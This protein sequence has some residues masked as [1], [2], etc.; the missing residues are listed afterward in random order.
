MSIIV[1]LGICVDIQRAFI[2]VLCQG[3]TGELRVE[4]GLGVEHLVGVAVV[5]LPE[6]NIAIEV[7]ILDV[8]A[9]VWNQNRTKDSSWWLCNGRHHVLTAAYELDLVV[10]ELPLL[11]GYIV[12]LPFLEND[13]VGGVW[14][15]VCGTL[16][17]GREWVVRQARYKA[18]R[19]K[20]SKAR[21]GRAPHRGTLTQTSIDTLVRARQLDLTLAAGGHSPVANDVPRS[22]RS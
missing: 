10:V 17:S 14:T 4:D 20:A 13:A 8:E 5:T 12:A 2:D 6:L 18:A 11:L 15:L 16:S 22:G 21:R 7:A 3:T 1:N 19:K 9:E